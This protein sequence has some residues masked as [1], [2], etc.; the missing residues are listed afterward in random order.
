ML[1]IYI[2]RF[3][4]S[5]YFGIV[6]K[7]IRAHIWYMMWFIFTKGILYAKR[8]LRRDFQAQLPLFNFLISS[9]EKI[10]Q[11]ILCVGSVKVNCMCSKLWALHECSQNL[12]SINKFLD[13]NFTLCYFYISRRQFF[14]LIFSTSW[15]T[16]KICK[17][18]FNRNFILQWINF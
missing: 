13:G 9:F 3:R 17:K 14:G 16:E 5:I 12:Y 18:F 15:S 10:H 1:V 11:K 2:V 8:I 4:C 7:I 6:S